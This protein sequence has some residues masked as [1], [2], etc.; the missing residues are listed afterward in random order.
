MKIFTG[1]TIR[2][3]H[4]NDNGTRSTVASR[5]YKTY[6]NMKSR[7]LN[8]ND[9]KYCN[10]GERGIFV[11][12]RWLGEKGFDNFYEDMGERPIGLTLERI[13]ND[14]GYSPS[15]CKWSTYAEQNHNQRTRKTRIGKY[16]G[17]YYLNNTAKNKYRSLIRILNKNYHLGYF[18]TEIEA[19]IAYNII[20]LE[21]YG[22]ESILNKVD[23]RQ[24]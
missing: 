19:A 11:C 14:L 8:K 22:N 16:R 15:N 21:W 18:K 6:T 20:A 13:N 9:K 12:D 4:Y 1:K 23:I 2:G 10:Y 24:I 7:C 5:T 17:V 3:S